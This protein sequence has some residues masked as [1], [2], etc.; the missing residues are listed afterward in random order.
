MRRMHFRRIIVGV[1]A[2]F[3]LQASFIPT[4]LA[5]D[6]PP[7]DGLV[8]IAT[9][10]DTTVLTRADRDRLEAELEAYDRETTNQ[11]AIV[12]L[13]SLQGEPIEDV[14]I[15]IGR[16]WGIGS[17]KNNGILIVFSYDDRE[18]RIDVGYGLEG[19]VP[20]I[21]AG[22]II[23]T[24]MI[25]KFREGDYA[26]GFE[27][28]VDSLKKHI[29]GEYTADRYTESENGGVAPFLIFFLFVAFQ[30]TLAFLARSKSWWQGGVIGAVGGVV[31]VLLFG[32]WLAIPLLTV[33][34]LFVDFIV[35][36]APSGRRGSRWGGGGFGGG[37]FGGG[38]SGGGFGGFGG[39]SFG[40]GGA[41]GKW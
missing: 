14:G 4:V 26:G 15:T 10:P 21:V 36:R 41:N 30:A 33:L 29:G 20:D 39:G 9:L 8:T 24:D 18:A 12:I 22:G 3:S 13:Q 1:V 7:N 25:P 6:V 37:G 32:W 16:K 27:A 11:I 2:A 23:N 40:G 5:F 28:A 38:S 34:G 17:S 35:S 19:A 31:L